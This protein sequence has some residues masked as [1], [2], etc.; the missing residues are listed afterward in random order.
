MQFLVVRLTDD[1]PPRIAF[2]LLPDQ[3]DTADSSADRVTELEA[4]LR[5]IAAEVRAAGVIEEIDRLPAPGEHP[6]LDELTGRQWEILVRL[7]RGDRVPTIAEELHVSPSTVR[8]HLTA[9]FSR[10]EVHSQAELLALL[11]PR[12]QGTP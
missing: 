10:F 9:I 3:V 6:Q 4:R 1:R 5:R 7:L 12:W 8:N 11:R 2:A